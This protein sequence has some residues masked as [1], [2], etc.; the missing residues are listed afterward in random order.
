[1]TP[2]EVRATLGE[3]KDVTEGPGGANWYYDCP[4]WVPRPPISVSFGKDGRVRH[5]Y[6]VD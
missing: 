2:D 4:W 1:M 5:V 3:P 6:I